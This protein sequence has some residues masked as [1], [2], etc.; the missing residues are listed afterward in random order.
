MSVSK[1]TLFLQNYK[2]VNQRLM[3]DWDIPAVNGIIHVIEAPLT[4]PPMLV[5]F[6]EVFTTKI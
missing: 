2:K 5:S 6:V 3:L 1:S 4:A